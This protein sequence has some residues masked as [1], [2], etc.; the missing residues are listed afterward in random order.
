[1]SA[2]TTC[3][4]GLL[5]MN[6]FGGFT[7]YLLDRTGDPDALCKQAKFDLIHKLAKVP[8]CAEVFSN[9]EYLLFREYIREGVHFTVQEPPQVAFEEA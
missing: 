5:H 6:Q 8:N 9:R 3:S 1:M 4:Y 7:E 2:L